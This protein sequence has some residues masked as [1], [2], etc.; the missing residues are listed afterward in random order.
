MMRS[1]SRKF[2]KREATSKSWRKSFW[3]RARGSTFH[4]MVS[5]MAVNTQFSSPAA[6]KRGGGGGRR[7]MMV[8]W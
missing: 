2:R 4:A 5:V 6:S 3:K 7:P 1:A 8:R